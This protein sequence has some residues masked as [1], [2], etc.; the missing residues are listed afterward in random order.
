MMSRSQNQIFR[1][2]DIA[3]IVLIFAIGIGFSVYVVNFPQDKIVER[4]MSYEKIIRSIL[5]HLSIVVIS[6][7]LAIATSVPL[8]LI[9]TRPKYKKFAKTVLGVVNIGQTIPSLAIVALFVGLLGIGT[10]TA[11]LALWIYSLL[12]ILNN[13]LV[14]ILSVEPSIIE[15]AKGMGMLPKRILFKIEIPL[16]MPI[17]IAGIRTAV[18]INIGTAIFAAFVGGGGLGDLIISGNNV[19]RWQIL[20]LGASLPALMALLSD[21]IFGAIERKTTI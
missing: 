21:I 11:I 20:V 6:S 10:R 9:L 19:N 16:A 2:K 3:L 12:P 17:I 15:A 7:M 5:Q 4:F 13:T 14:G 18:T 1:L 8:G